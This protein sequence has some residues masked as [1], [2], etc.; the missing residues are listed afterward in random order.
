VKSKTAAQQTSRGLLLQPPPGDLT[1]PYPALPYLKAYAERDGH[2]VGV[3][4]LGIECFYHLV[5]QDHLDKLAARAAAIRKRL[6]ARTSLNEEEQRQYGLLVGA[7]GLAA[8]P[9]TI[10]G[11]LKS[12]RDGNSFF[13]HRRYLQAVRTLDALFQLISGVHYP[14]AV[15]PS[16]YPVAQSLNSIE[17]VLV[18]REPSVNPYADYY[19]TKLIPQ[20]AADPPAVIGISMEFAAQS[21][22]AI[23]LGNLLKERFPGI[24]ITM[25]G[26]YLSQWVQL[27]GETQ[28]EWLFSCTDSIVCGEGENA[29]A[30]LLE[31][32]ASGSS[33]GCV[34]NLVYRDHL[35]GRVCRPEKLEY[36]D[37]ADLPP[38]DYTDLDL[39]AY[40]IP[41]PVIPYVISRGCYWGRC[42]FCQNRYG[43]KRMR[44]YQTVPVEK[45][46][47]EMTD[48]ADRY[49]STHFNFSN[50][51]VD[52]PYLK[53]FSE[54][55][56]AAGKRFVWNTDL[57]AERAFT[58]ELCRT[59]AQA[60]L[61]CVAIGFESACQRTLDR[62]DKGNDVEIV[63]RVMKDLYD[64]GVAVQAMGFFG[65]PG[66][67]ETEA[68][69]TVRFL[70]DNRER[71]SYYVMGLLM[72]VPGSRLHETPHRFGVASV[73]YEGNS[74]MA[75]QP[76]WRSPARISSQ[77]V[78]RLYARLSGLEK[79]YAIN[80][81]PYVGALS[82][83]HGFLYFRQGQDI[84][85]R[86]REEEKDR[87]KALHRPFHLSDKRAAEKKLKSLVP[88]LA[89]GVTIYRSRF[90]VD[91]I[92][93][94]G[95]PLLAAGARDYL[96]HP[97]GPAIRLGPLEIELIA[98]MDGKR[99]LKSVL[100]RFRGNSY[101]SVVH[102]L[103][104]L[105]AQ[106]LVLFR[107]S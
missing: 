9:R 79:T 88:R 65:F 60:G 47:E 21:V 83:N 45:A 50:D 18:H 62:M 15:T 102:F 98:N 49:G 70:E 24:H 43:E 11:L 12:F 95:G 91:R 8:K 41:Q 30:G 89:A 53:R 94:H 63:G 81:Y 51:V 17:S 22:Q 87:F 58:K 105:V 72:V 97:S 75:P 1:G 7:V 66:E 23:V 71:I 40:L 6:E 82:T 27:M 57:R 31:C 14:T 55:V 84:L 2:K 80:D 5:E 93:A 59:L 68:E 28:F 64:A 35:T 39:N 107:T 26:A 33:L 67:T 99:N 106:G 25:G 36:P 13:N 32:A 42:V 76:V 92:P 20:I 61:N 96:A 4:D 104:S 38:P 74:L 3:R 54:T 19:E 29:F 52:P 86:L 77:A 44:R 37:L 85:K 100:G 78:N 90:P 48:L 73:S 10:L 46:V 16:D 56:I 101:G 103:L 69:T 34:P